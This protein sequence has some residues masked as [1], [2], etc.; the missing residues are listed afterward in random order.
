MK[1]N[2]EACVY[3]RRGSLFIR[4]SSQTE[5][6]LWIEEGP[7]TMI[8]S[9]S[10]SEEVGQAARDALA[11]SGK[12]IPH[13]TEWKSVDEDNPILELAGIKQ[14]ST[15]RRGARVVGIALYDGKLELT[16]TENEGSEGFSDLNDDALCLSPDASTAELGAAIYDTLKRCK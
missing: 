16:P 2:R 10:K 6:G 15:F 1:E 13:P 14:W 4:W 5:V 11:R 12:I 8:P 7:C 3:E 9:N